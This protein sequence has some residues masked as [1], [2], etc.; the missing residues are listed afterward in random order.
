[1]KTIDLGKGFTTAIDD[2][3]FDLVGLMKWRPS[4]RRGSSHVYAQRMV[5]D[6][7]EKKIRCL[8]LH[9]VLMGALPGQLVDHRDSNGLNNQ[10]YNLRVCS[11]LQNNQH[12]RKVKTNTS[13]RFKGVCKRKD[14]NRWEAY[15]KINGSRKHLGSFVEELAA[16]QAYN[17]AATIHHGEYAL[18]NT[19]QTVLT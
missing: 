15:I 17:A 1:M 8:L 3:D 14:C 13:S 10:R 6:K 9:R 2:S 5:W 19:F 16:A 18:L 4:A 12:V 7:K 11:R